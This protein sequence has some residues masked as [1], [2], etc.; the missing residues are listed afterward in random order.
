M[1]AEEPKRVRIA[2]SIAAVVAAALFSAYCYRERL[3]FLYFSRIGYRWHFP[4]DN[5]S[6]SVVAAD[7][8]QGVLR[9][10]FSDLAYSDTSPFE[11]CV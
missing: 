2:L 1:R 5:N 3:A 11:R 9:P 6:P 7:E 10:T 8:R 4:L